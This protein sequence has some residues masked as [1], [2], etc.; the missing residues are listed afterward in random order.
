MQYSYRLLYFDLLPPSPFMREVNKVAFSFW[1]SMLVMAFGWSA[2]VITTDPLRGITTD[3]IVV[4]TFVAEIW[5]LSLLTTSTWKLRQYRGAAR[6]LGPEV[7]QLLYPWVGILVVNTTILVFALVDRASQTSQP[8]QVLYKILGAELAPILAF[9]VPVIKKWLPQFEPMRFVRVFQRGLAIL[10]GRELG[11][12]ADQH[13]RN[14]VEFQYEFTKYIEGKG[15]STEFSDASYAQ[16]SNGETLAMFQKTLSCLYETSGTLGKRVG[17]HF[18]GRHWTMLDVG[19]GEGIF[20]TELLANCSTLPQ[21]LTV[22]DPSELNVRA[23]RTR[24]A[25]SYENIR[26]I[27]AYAKGVE[28]VIDDLP[29]VNFLLASHSLYAVL[30]NSKRRGTRVIRELAKRTT[31]GFAVFIMASQDSYLYTIKRTVLGHLHRIDRSSYGE[32]LRGLMSSEI[33]HTVESFDSVVDVS[34]LLDDYE[35]LISWLSYFCR[36]DAEE[37]RPYYDVCQAVVRDTAIDVKCLPKAERLR[38]EDSGTMS[39]MELTDS[40]KVVYHK[41]IVITVPSERQITRV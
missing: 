11:V 13:A 24:V 19:G 26:N 31:D 15:G 21:V 25:G 32:D 33:A 37:I 7:Y 27:D 39:R 14:V 35:G 3:V 34:A 36:V 22:L 20:T 9:E 41:E 5:Y 23:Y 30:D 29:V 38:M 28:D 40:S 12:K 6:Q 16:Y 17:D 10:L 2:N 1:L 18:R 8:G 4:G